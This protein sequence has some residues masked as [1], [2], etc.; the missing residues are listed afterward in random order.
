MA[1]THT[2]THV[3]TWMMHIKRQILDLYLFSCVGFSSLVL[4]IL[5]ERYK[6]QISGRWMDGWALVHFG[7]PLYLNENI[8]LKYTFNIHLVPFHF[9]FIIP[10]LIL[11]RF[12]FRTMCVCVFFRSKSRILLLFL[13]PF[14]YINREDILVPK[15]INFSGFLFR[16]CVVII[17]QN[18]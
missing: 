2:R 9:V 5:M 16:V 17:T 15:T 6:K 8:L 7:Q 14:Y 4:L 3:N 13:E 11:P 1:Q 12:V 10:C 18:K